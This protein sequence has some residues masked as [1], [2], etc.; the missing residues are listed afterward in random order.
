MDVRLTSAAF[1]K[2]NRYERFK[3]TTTP[4]NVSKGAFWSLEHLIRHKES[5]QVIKE[6]SNLS[7][8]FE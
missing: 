6:A 1:A 4:Q 3:K 5:I 8:E 7:E 2:V